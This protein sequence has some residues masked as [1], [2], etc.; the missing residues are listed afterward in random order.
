MA[1]TPDLP[2]K[3]QT[4]APTPRSTATQEAKVIVSRQ[5]FNDFAAI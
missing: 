2:R 3:S 4:P 5:V 1:T